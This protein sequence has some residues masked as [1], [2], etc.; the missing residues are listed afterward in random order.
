MPAK[1]WADQ[2]VAGVMAL[3]ELLTDRE[4]VIQRLRD[5]GLRVTGPRMEVLQVLAAGGHLD[6]EAITAA[7]RER[8]GTLT[9]QAVYEM[10]RHFL[11]TGL[12][13][14]FERPGWP[15]VFEVMGEPHQHAL[16]VDCGRV[17]NVEAKAPSPPKKGLT[18][19]RMTSADIV[20]RGHCPECRTA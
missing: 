17:E 3:D 7:A 8:L 10:L 13:M 6:V 1:F 5:V 12:V 16:C 19:W 14:K 15:A 2:M 11:E 18:D 20:F 4:A 9:S